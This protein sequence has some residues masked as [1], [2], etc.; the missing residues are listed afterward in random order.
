MTTMNP[1]QTDAVA[2]QYRRLAQRFAERVEAAPADRWDASS[3]C[4]GWTARDVVRHVVETETEMATR[5]G[6]TVSPG[7]SVDD[8]PVA[9]WRHTSGEM[10]RFLDDPATATIEYDG[11]FG[12]STMAEAFASFYSVDLVVHA[13]DIARATGTD[14]TIAADDLALVQGFVDGLTDDT[15]SMLRSPGAFGPEVEAPAAADEQT[16]LLAFLGRR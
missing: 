1:S 8:D 4:E 12:R 5:L 3:P 16:K 10:Q 6:L 9:A 7:P 11:M 13:W 2:Q 15:R 14:E